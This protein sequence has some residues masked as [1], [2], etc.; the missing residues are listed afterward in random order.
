MAIQLWKEIQHRAMLE[1]IGPW[2]IITTCITINQNVQQAAW[3][4]IWPIFTTTW[5]KKSGTVH[6]HYETIHWNF[7]LITFSEYFDSFQSGAICLLR[8]L[9]FHF[10]RSFTQ[11]YFHFCLWFVLAAGKSSSYDVVHILNVSLGTSNTQCAINF[12]KEHIA[13]EKNID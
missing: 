10:K 2:D 13:E 12:F 9:I 11:K 6:S 4:K 7:F 8:C 1:L 3:L 5:G